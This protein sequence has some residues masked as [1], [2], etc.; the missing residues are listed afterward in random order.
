LRWVLF[1]AIPPPY[2]ARSFLQELAHS[3]FRQRNPKGRAGF[4]LGF[5]GL[6]AKL[7]LPSNP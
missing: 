6:K 2:L 4:A 1:L 7:A 5:N 3:H